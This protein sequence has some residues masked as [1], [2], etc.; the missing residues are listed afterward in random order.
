MWSTGNV[1]GGKAVPPALDSN[2]ISDLCEKVDAVG[3]KGVA[4]NASEIYQSLVVLPAQRTRRIRGLEMSAYAGSCIE[5]FRS[6]SV[7]LVLPGLQ[8]YVK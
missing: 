2:W 3:D 7:F 6:V 1:K 5:C 4:L 8:Q